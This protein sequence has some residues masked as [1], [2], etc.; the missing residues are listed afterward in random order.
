ME[1][2]IVVIIPAYNEEQSIAKVVHDLPKDWVKTIVV[3]NNNSTDNTKNV[4]LAAGATV[5]DEPLPGYG[6]ACLKGLDYLR[7][8][9]IKPDIVVFIDGDYSDFPEE[10]PLVV[11]PIL[12]GHYDMVIGSRA[13][14]QRENGS[15]QPD[16][17][18][19]V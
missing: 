10:L 7:K 12:D 18:S 14:G 11:Q 6:N 2:H 15:M 1:H 4:A 16:R 17:K 5:V 9:A 13:L 8:Q 3:C 19:V